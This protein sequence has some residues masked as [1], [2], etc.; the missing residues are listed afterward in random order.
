MAKIN[1]GG[2]WGFCLDKEKVGIE[3]SY[4]KNAFEDHINLPTTVSEAK[5]GTPSEEQNTYFLTD[6]YLFEGYTWYSREIELTDTIGKELFLILE[7]TRT[8]HVWVDDSYVGSENSLC[9][10]HRYC[11]TPYLKQHKHKLTIMVDN[12]SCPVKGGHMTSQDTQTNWNGITG[13]IYLEVY[14][15][16]YLTGVKLYPDTAKRQIIVKAV[17]KGVE[18]ALAKVTV[19]DAEDNYYPEMKQQ[20]KEGENSFSFAMDNTA[21]L[22]SE[23]TPYLYCL[24]IK[25]EED[26]YS[27]PFG[28]RDFKAGIKYFEINGSRTFLRGKHDGLI[29]PM[30]GYAPTDLK[31]WLEVLT[32][33][34]SYGINHYRFHTCCPPEAAFT[35]A[36]ML[37]MYME[38]ELPFWGTIT[39]EGEENHDEKAQQYLLREGFRI[40][41]EFGNHPSFVMMSLGNELWGSKSKLNEIL[42]K[43]KSYDNRHR[44]TQGSNNFQFANCILDNED[45]Y[46]G[47]RFSRDRLF[48][49]SYAMCDAPQGH[50]QTKIPD[51]LHNYNEMIRP[52]QLTGNAEGEGD[53]TIQYGT[54]TKTVKAEA[55]EEIIPQIPVVSHEIG[56]YAMYPDFSEISRYTG[57]LKARNLEVFRE[58]LEKEGML[59]YGDK[60][61]RASGRLAAECYKSEIE[62]ALRSS[63][64]AGFQLLDLQ[65]F[66]GQGTALVGILNSFMKSKGLITEEEWREFCSD[67]VILAELPKLVYSAGEKVTIGILLANFGQKPVYQPKVELTIEESNTSKGNSADREMKDNNS[68]DIKVK[69]NAADREMKGNTADKEMNANSSDKEITLVKTEM[70]LPQQFA[71]GVYRLCDFDINL[72]VVLQ[73]GKVTLNIGISGTHIRNHYTLWLYP[74]T[75]LTEDQPAEEVSV[76]EK[77]LHD[78]DTTTNIDVKIT[79]NLDEA[80][81]LL[82][83]GSRVLLFPK[84]LDEKNS[85]E[86][87]YCTDFWCYPMF[88]SISESMNRPV[89]IGT[90]GLLINEKHPVFENFPTEYYTTPQWYDII[91]ASRP[92]ILDGSDIQPVV[93]TIDNFERNHRL[94]MIFELQVGNGKLFVCT[95]KLQELKDSLPAAHLMRSILNYVRSEKFT[96]VSVTDAEDLKRIFKK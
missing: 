92:I 64:L 49:G 18:K 68:A 74:D 32:T 13:G 19:A 40:L 58:R 38:P 77:R 69:G 30:T 76:E 66:A 39:E 82:E 65:D 10:A 47:V 1:L 25:L 14:N 62:T 15:S 84:E 23:H 9:T 26:S 61:F 90:H 70:I 24:H 72:P 46:C 71:N 44:Y 48:R 17:L 93:W 4:Y 8:S 81:L 50:I 51:M 35:A 83:K 78:A 59:P 67:T 79:D 11:L 60:F 21:K 52:S 53:I 85:I 75:A 88:R 91:S 54:G 45:F 29:F 80:L 5:K 33:A 22:W 6:P 3:K 31:S 20:L 7:R 12:T 37:G 57:V 27:F 28:L 95:S 36:D 86:G 56:Q 73:P 42:G 55:S 16:I 43:Y 41:D 87:T 2:G 34:K 94:G 63:E 89:P 96:P